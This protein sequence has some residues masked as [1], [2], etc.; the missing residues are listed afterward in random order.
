MPKLQSEAHQVFSSAESASH[1]LHQYYDL[2]SVSAQHQL[3]INGD[4][5]RA[6]EAD[7]VAGFRDRCFF[8]HRLHRHNDIVST[9]PQQTS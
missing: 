3:E 8:V 1:H 5:F 2:W 6:V 7:N 9:R 4:P